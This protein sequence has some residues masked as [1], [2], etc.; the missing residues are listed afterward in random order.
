MV[1]SSIF[2]LPSVEEQRILQVTSGF[3]RARIVFSYPGYLMLGFL[4]TA[5]GAVIYVLEYRSA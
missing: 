3:A 4:G 2:G 5:K 1:I